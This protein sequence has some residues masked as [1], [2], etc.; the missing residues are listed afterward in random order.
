M[1]K[2]NK[3]NYNSIIKKMQSRAAYL[4]KHHYK[5][6]IDR[7]Y[8]KLMIE[9]LMANGRCHL[10]AVFKN[11]LIQD[12]ISD[13]LR[14]FYTYEE[15]IN[16]LKKLF[17]F[18]Q[19][20][21]VIFP[22]YTPLIES[23]YLYNN[24]IRKQRII[25]AQQDLEGKGDKSK[26]K[27][28]N[29]KENINTDENI[30]NSTIFG[31]ILSPSE[32]VLRIMFGIE[33]KEKKLNKMNLDVP[34]NIDKIKDNDEYN[35][36]DY[37]KSEYIEMKNLIKEVESAEENLKNTN[38]N[39][40]VGYKFNSNNTLKY[41]L[42]L[43]SSPNNNETKNKHYEKVNSITNN[44][45][46]ITSSSYINNINPIK[47][48]SNQNLKFKDNIIYSQKGKINFNNK[49]SLTLTISDIKNK[50]KNFS[51]SSYNN[52][53]I[54][55]TTHKKNKST[56][57]TKTLY[58]SNFL[59][60]NNYLNNLIKC[61]K[62]AISKHN[63]NSHSINTSRLNTNSHN[64]FIL[65]NNF[66]FNSKINPL[67]INNKTT[68][69]VKSNKLLGKVPKMDMKK[70]QII[71]KKGNNKIFA[72]T[73]RSINRN[74]NYILNNPNIFFG[75]TE[76]LQ[77]ERIIMKKRNQKKELI[78][79]AIT[80]KINFSPSNSKSKTIFGE[81][82]NNRQIFLAKELNL[83]LMN[84]YNKN[85]QNLSLK[86]LNKT[87]KKLQINENEYNANSKGNFSDRFNKKFIKQEL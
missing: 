58:G 83:K 38:Q 23:K 3:N 52:K 82:N 33:K 36:N 77:S 5:K 22:N 31:D 63:S 75:N 40:L 41:K 53:N 86:K 13:Y 68:S 14:R 6:Y 55:S 26:S 81:K 59:I 54:A 76:L 64:K 21:S 32:S 9:N 62:R 42:K 71:N 87:Q 4:C 24:V 61:E 72:T 79:N 73:N 69:S 27:K 7:S 15:S 30:F 51:I 8:N 44:S 20:T 35:D 17:K 1:N 16:R 34:D 2:E 66:P 10:V 57:P 25:D 56:I 39:S 43:I 48:Q 60:N 70:L 19:E 78:K 45:T 67:N 46:N 74:H 49:N 85:N 80:P 29:K 47:I 37:D 18:H 65:N 28:K 12:D 84:Q 11:Y 50:D